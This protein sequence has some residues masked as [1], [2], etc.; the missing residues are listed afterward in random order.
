VL[1]KKFIMFK[2]LS[3]ITLITIALFGCKNAKVV[4]LPEKTVIAK[5]PARALKVRP[6][7][8]GS[9]TRTFDLLHT[10]ID[11][12]FNWEKSQMYGKAWLTLTPYFYA[13]DSLVL[14]ARGMDINKLEL[15]GE[16]NLPL[17][18]TYDSLK[19]HIFLGKNYTRKD[20]IKIFVDYTITDDKGLYFI[21]PKGEDKGKP[22]QIWTQGET[23]SNSVWFPTFDSPNERC[24]EEINIT[25][26]DKYK[27][28]SNGILNHSELNG[29]G[30]RTDYWKMDLPI[31]PYLFM[32]A[33]GDFSVVKDHW[34]DK[35]VNYYVDHKYEQYVKDYVS[36][37]MEN[38][39]AVIHGDF[40]E[41]TKREMIDGSAGEDVISHEL[42]HHWF[43]DYVTCESW[44]NIP[45]NESFATYGEYLWNEYKHGLDK[46]DMGIQND[47]AGY[48]RQYQQGGQVDMIRFNY[49]SRE[50]LF[51]AN[52]YF[53]SLKLYLE[54]NKFTAVELPQLRLAFEKVTG[55]DLNWFFN[56]W[57]YASGHPIL[58]IDY[59][60]NDSLKTETVTVEQMQ[61]F[62]KTP[63][64]KLP[65]KIDIYV[66]GKKETKKVTI[67]KEKND[68]TFNIATQP[69][70]VNFD[71]D[72]MLLCEK[73]DNHT[74]QE[75]AYLF[76]HAP[77]YLDR[78]EAIRNLSK[79]DTDIAVKGEI[80][81]MSDPFYNIRRVAIRGIK[82][83]AG[84]S[85]EKVFSKL[86]D[87]AKNDNNSL[88]RGDAINALATYFKDKEE[89]KTIFAD[90]VK[91][92]SYYVVG[93]SLDAL[94]QTDGQEAL[95]VAKGLETD[96]DEN[97]INAIASVY[98][99]NGTEKQLTYFIE[100]N[101]KIKGYGKYSFIMSFTEYLKKQDQNTIQKGLPILKDVATNS[102]QWWMRMVGIRGL[103]SLNEM[104]SSRIHIAETELK[105][106]KPG[107]DKELELRSDLD[108]NKNLKS[109]LDV[110]INEIETSEKNPQLRKM[111]GLKD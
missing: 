109:E 44:A 90:G 33:I 73:E 6:V 110:I 32:M 30:T 62:D 55:E 82:I 76:Y 59:N 66:N 27:T 61:D 43:G 81:G 12:H 50:D 101:N 26:A 92:Q 75:W 22:M 77:K 10:K 1:S 24:A 111:L 89:V 25:V 31:A 21:N 104:Y 63:L 17:I 38:V 40:V 35:E 4:N 19:L 36:G 84:K 88:V 69:D 51:D 49:R 98:A 65:I 103:T 46:A 97:I 64:Y 99:D 106:E 18:Y 68:F 41:Q 70:L 54:T 2:K 28:L 91:E 96:E 107:S 100:I 94:S 87:L 67:D 9:N 78:Y 93:K 11:A 14:D 102:E 8:H 7:Y 37:A 58:K 86:M 79:S 23:Q 105:K 71:A 13:T 3:L 42:F 48:L 16:N 72:K 39:T 20:T 47:M 52:T 29:D 95:K 60:Y 15:V 108:K 45:L 5:N 74:I 85:P 57:F 34:R 56:Q 80:D 83:A 53:A